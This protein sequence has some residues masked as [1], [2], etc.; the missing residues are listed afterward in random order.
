MTQEVVTVRQEDLCTIANAVGTMKHD[1]DNGKTRYLVQEID[2]IHE[3][4][5]RWAI[6]ESVLGGSCHDDHRC[7][8]C[9]ESGPLPMARFARRQQAGANQPARGVLRY[10]DEPEVSGPVVHAGELQ[11]QERRR[12]YHEGAEFILEP[13]SDSVV[14]V[15]HREQTGYFGFNR[16]WD[17]SR[18]YTRCRIEAVVRSDG[19]DGSSIVSYSTPD[20]ALD[21][22]CHAMLDDQRVEDSRRINPEQRKRAARKV[23]EEFLEDLPD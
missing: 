9:Q 4:V 21:D 17:P 19:I 15:T 3:V 13:L 2:K 16:K 12:Y 10:S 8:L 7:R 11:L 6:D 23:L 18:P 20:D 1:L 14:R 22:L 5:E